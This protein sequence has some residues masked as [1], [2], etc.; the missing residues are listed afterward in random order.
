MFPF[1]SHAAVVFLLLLSDDKMLFVLLPFPAIELVINETPTAKTTTTPAIHE[2]K[3]AV[4][5][6]F[7][8]LLLSL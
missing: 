6:F 7:G 2:I 3:I 5:F 8:F 1:L 4:L